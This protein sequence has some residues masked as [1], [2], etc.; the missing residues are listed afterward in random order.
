MSLLCAAWYHRMM[1]IHRELFGVTAGHPAQAPSDVWGYTL[2]VGP[3]LCVTVWTYGATL[4]EVRVP[5]RRGHRDNVVLRLA[6]LAGYQD[7]G[8]TA[9]LGAVLGRFCRSVSQG[10]FRLDGHAYQLSRNAGRHHIH[11]GAPGFDRFNWD[12][13][14]GRDGDALVVRLRLARPAGDQGYPGALTAEVGYR[15]EP[16][17]RLVIDYRATTTAST[18]VSLTNHAFWR[19]GGEPAVDR[20]VLA[21]NATRMVAL[22]GEFLPHPGPP[23]P[24]RGGRFDFRQPRPIGDTALDTF[25]ALDDPAWAARVSH[26]DSGRSLRISTDQPGVGIYSGDHLPAPRA[27]L[28]LQPSA[29]PDAPNRPDFPACRLDPGQ[30]Y[31]H[32]SSYE[33]TV[34]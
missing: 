19:L 16:A 23:V 12:A 32:R 15:A 7:P 4:V 22:D 28:C 21:V 29:W 1:R 9:Y 3:D 5:D 13:E 8:H 2:D 24:V 30:T 34:D 10:R 6:D 25:F 18:I 27:G 14:A 26:P 11:G 33:R 17:G 20:H 31:R